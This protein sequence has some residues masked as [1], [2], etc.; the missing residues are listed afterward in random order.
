M[1]LTEHFLENKTNLKKLR[2]KNNYFSCAKP[3]FIGQLQLGKLFNFF[4]VIVN[5]LK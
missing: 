3:I 2:E 5:I 1:V 4:N